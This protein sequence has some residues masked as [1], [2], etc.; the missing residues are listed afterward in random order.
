ML[1]IDPVGREGLVGAAEDRATVLPL[2]G[3]GG[4]AELAILCREEV[5]GFLTVSET[6][7]RGR[8]GAG[9]GLLAEPTEPV[10][11]ARRMGSSEGFVL[12]DADNDC[13]ARAGAFAFAGTTDILREECVAVVVGLDDV[14]DAKVGLETV[15]GDVVAFFKAGALD[16]TTPPAV[17][18]GLTEPEPYVPEFNTC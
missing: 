17:T 5:G 11:E 14:D 9:I 10:G 4:F 3:P 18:L 13:L 1:E 8:P 2:L 16:L 6:E 7:A 12:A 15:G